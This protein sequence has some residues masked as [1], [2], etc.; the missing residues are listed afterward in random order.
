MDFV[1]GETFPKLMGYLALLALIAILGIAPTGVLLMLTA[2]HEYWHFCLAFTITMFAGLNSG[3]SI[4]TGLKERHLYTMYRII[5]PG[6]FTEELYFPPTAGELLENTLPKLAIGFG[7][8]AGLFWPMDI[9]G[10]DV[11]K[12]IIMGAHH[13]VLGTIVAAAAILVPLIYNTTPKGWRY[14]QGEITA[15]MFQN[16]AMYQDIR[17]K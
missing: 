5:P 13:P 10:S 15:S 17:R 1:A 12:G 8:A 3:K 11:E 14:K 4:Y 7:M 16:R 2:K 6:Q 9:I